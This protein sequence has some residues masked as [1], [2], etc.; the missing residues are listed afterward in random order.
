[1]I[2]ADDPQ[3]RLM[4]FDHLGDV[5]DEDRIALVLGD[6]DVADVVELLIDDLGS[7]GDVGRVERVDRPCPG[8]RSRARCAT[9]SPG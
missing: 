5:T 3:P 6:D 2:P 7:L 8:A 4:P 1:M 9:G